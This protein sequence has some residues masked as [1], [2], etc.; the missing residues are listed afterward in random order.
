MPT[1]LINWLLRRRPPEPDAPAGAREPRRS[2][3]SFWD[4]SGEHEPLAVAIESRQACVIRSRTAAH[5]LTVSRHADHCLLVAPEGRD[6]ARRT[7]ELAKKI[8]KKDRRAIVAI[9]RC[10]D[11]SVFAGLHGNGIQ[12]V[13]LSK[14]DALLKISRMVRAG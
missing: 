4:E 1:S 11:S 13:R 14:E 2:L 6:Q 12:L 9:D 8:G 3:V 7:A 10:A 5:F